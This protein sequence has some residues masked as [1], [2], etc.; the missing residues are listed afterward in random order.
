[1]RFHA[2]LLLLFSASFSSAQ[3]AEES[4]SVYSEHPRLL[5]NAQRL[6]LLT[7]EKQ[8]DTIRWAQ[9]R[10]LADGNVNFPEPGFANALLF[11]IAADRK[12]GER[13]VTWAVTGAGTD[14]RQIALVYDWCHELLTETQ[15]SALEQKLTR[16]LVPSVD[17]AAKARDA[18]FAA[19]ALGE[20]SASSEKVLRA[21]VTNWWRGKYVPQIRKT[22]AIPHQ[23][24]YPVLEFVHVYRDNLQIELRDNLAQVWETLAQYRVLSYYPAPYPAGENEY[25][26][27][28]FTGGG[29][30]DLRLAALV[31][32]AEFALIALDSNATEM[33]FL[34]G[35][36]LHDRFNLRSAFGAPYEFLWANPY[37][38]GLPYQKVALYLHQPNGVLLARSHW[39]DDAEWIGIVNGRL[40]VFRDGRIAQATGQRL[41]VGELAIVQTNGSATFQVKPDSES[42]WILTGLS[43]SS[44]VDVEVDDEELTQMKTGASGLLELRF[45]RKDGQRGYVR[46]R[47]E[48]RHS[49]ANTARI[50]TANSTPM[51]PKAKPPI[52]TAKNTT[53][54]LNPVPRPT[55]FGVR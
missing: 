27:P 43:P 35:W 1:M 33:Q 44:I 9:L 8:R 21:L 6:R 42:V 32:A 30:P 36:L 20:V 45:Q 22:G 18:A 31:R 39:D 19:I 4:Y 5:L 55:N 37:Q 13:A 11:R 15:R 51:G 29:E 3:P 10:L 23:D 17:S 28:F 49:T 7:R 16:A 54:G 26:I 50:G 24:L 34:Q 25:R 46:P 2:A 41:S 38:P 53:S 48:R 40:Q 47:R 12:A 52:S 14:I